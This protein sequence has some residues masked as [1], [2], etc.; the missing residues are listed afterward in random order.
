MVDELEELPRGVSV[1]RRRQAPP[2]R[3]DPGAHAS[4]HVV[5]RGSFHLF[6]QA[7][8]ERPVLSLQPGDLLLLS[9]APPGAPS[10]HC[11]TPPGEATPEPA[12]LLS[13]AYASSTAKDV[14]LTADEVQRER[15]LAA[16]V[17]LLR[18]ALVD[19]SAGQER[20]ARSLLEPLLAYVLDGQAR[21]RT[22]APADP[23]VARALSRMRESPAE[24]WSVAALAKAASLSRAAFARRFLAELG[25]PPLRHLA[26]LRM[27]LAARLLAEGDD[28]L[29]SIAVQVGYESEFAFSRA[30]KRHTGEAPGAFRRHRRAGHGLPKVRA[31]A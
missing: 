31:A 11:V 7:R 2:W 6:H 27:D 8:P 30:F 24:R 20:L 1:S 12:E 9:G 21:A 29:S 26:E 14:H 5:V 16:L 25:V 10:L 4:L 23:R 17:G 15:G 22:G 3:V 18:A 13:A 28:S 19:P